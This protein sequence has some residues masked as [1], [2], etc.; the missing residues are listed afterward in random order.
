M[1]KLSIIDT[2]LPSFDD[3]SNKFRISLKLIKLPS[4]YLIYNE[5]ILNNLKSLI[6]S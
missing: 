2:P 5:R 3:Y 4:R 1:Q 6:A